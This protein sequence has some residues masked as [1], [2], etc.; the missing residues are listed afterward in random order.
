MFTENSVYSNR[1]VYTP[2]VFAR[3]SLLYLQEAGSLSALKPHSST[4]NDL[5]SYLFFIVTDGSGQLKYDGKIYE[6]NKNTAVFIDCSKPYSHTTIED[7]WSL[8]W[9]HFNGSNMQVIYDKYLERGGLPSFTAI[10]CDKYS[11]LIDSIC[12]TA[13][14]D[15]YIKDMKINELLSSLLTLVMESSWNPE[16]QT[17]Q[18]RKS[19]KIDSVQQIK[20]FLDENWNKKIVLDELA[21]QFYIDKY[22]LTRLFKSHYG[23]SILTYITQVRITKAKQALRFS[24]S[25][26]ESISSSCGFES[27]NY[28]TRTFKRT[29][30]I[31]P[32]DYRKQWE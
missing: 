16:H 17:N 10:D 14:Q 21:N 30:G 25:S 28:F 2:S 11:N 18:G 4:R 12:T 1:I 31:T 29:E 13:S 15:S 23:T 3:Q 5:N 32:C 22:Y 24:D 6:L 9:V 26:I 7:L 19:Y 27:A 8:K 20:Q